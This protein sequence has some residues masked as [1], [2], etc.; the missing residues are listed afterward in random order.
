[1]ALVRFC[2]LRVLK[3]AT[4]VSLAL[5]GTACDTTT[6][7][8]VENEPDGQTNRPPAIVQQGPVF[9][10]GGFE[11]IS[12]YSPYGINL[13]VLVADPDGIDDISLVTA[14]V[15]SVRLARFL[16]RPDTSSTSCSYFSYADNETI[17]TSAILP[18]PTT[19]AGF[20]FMP[21][22]RVQGGLFQASSFG[23]TSSGFPDLIEASPVLEEWQGGCYYGSTGILGPIVVLPPAVLTQRTAIL[24]YAD[25]EYRGI[26]VTVY[27][28]VGATA[29]T[30]FPD[31]RIVFPSP[32]ERAAAP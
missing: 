15:D 23:G 20:S 14:S 2:A 27:D 18:V 1:M 11:Q 26:T 3:Q 13:W 10:P 5:F 31:L 19:F 8:I 12:S 21:L 4:L 32:E 29:T 17:A 24:T 22:T 9:P 30:S 16:L 6:K 25:V 28:K 7:V